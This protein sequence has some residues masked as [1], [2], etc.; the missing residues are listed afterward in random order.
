MVVL[1]KVGLACFVNKLSLR[2]NL[3]I[4][5]SVAKVIKIYGTIVGT[6]HP[7]HEGSSIF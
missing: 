4:L 7:L 2:S 1:F 6:P 5:D 3:N